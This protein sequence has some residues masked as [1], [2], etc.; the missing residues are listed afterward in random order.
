MST[1]ITD[2]LLRVLYDLYASIDR[3]ERLEQKVAERQSQIISRDAKVV[4]LEARIERMLKR[5]ETLEKKL[6]KADLGKQLAESVKRNERLSQHN[7]ELTEDWKAWAI[8]PAER[9]A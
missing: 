4:D 2:I 3:V 7:R 5:G 6:A 9:K 8:P 1:N